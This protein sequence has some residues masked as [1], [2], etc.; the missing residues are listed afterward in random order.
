MAVEIE[1]RAPDVDAAWR[2]VEARDPRYDGRFYFGVR[3]TGVYCKPS[4]AARRP[5]RENVRIFA[6]ADDAEAAGFRACRRCHPRDESKTSATARAVDRAREYLDRHV[7]RAVPLA[8]L[9]AAVRVSAWHL[10]RAFT[11]RVGLSPA[12]Y[13]RTRRVERLEAL[14]R[15]GDT[16]SRATYEAGFGSSSRVY[17]NAHEMLGMT[18]ASYRGGG[19]GVRITYAIE[20]SPIGRVLVA[21]T[22][23]GICAV[24]IGATDV[25]AEAA[26]RRD[27]PKA[28]F[29]R[30]QAVH[31]EWVDAA[32]AAVREP[33]RNATGMRLPLDISGSAFQMQVWRALQEI[34][35]GER[36]SYQEIASAIGRPTAA[37]A[38]ARACASNR[39]A[40]IIPC[41]RVVRGDGTLSGYR[42]G[43]DRKL[44]LLN[45]EG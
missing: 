19:A 34:P 33:R 42:W 22:D 8:E 44:A 45:E 17:E 38:V 32:L 18:P 11:D 43:V 35:A 28:T 5:R 3:T 16:V 26:V 6:T 14:L 31:R 23:R 39:V 9:A 12:K 25:D 13:H 41:H 2:A 37:R 21:T 27:F 20:D 7:D 40:V 1:L 29:V 30:D 4:C 24:A 36:R 10:Q 15:R